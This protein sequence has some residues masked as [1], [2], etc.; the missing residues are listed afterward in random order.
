LLK[1]ER[2]GSKEDEGTECD[3][4]GLVKIREITRPIKAKDDKERE[5]QA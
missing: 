3:K 5:R 4:D 2:L 1:R